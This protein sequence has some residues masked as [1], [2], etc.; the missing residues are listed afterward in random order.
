M[1]PTNRPS[2]AQL[3]SGLLLAAWLGLPTL[4]PAAP[5]SLAQVP[6][7]LVIDVQPNVFF[8][9]DDSGSMDA[10]VLK[11]DGAR[12]AHNDPQYGEVGNLSYPAAQV[13]DVLEHCVGYNV[14]AYDP[15]KEYTPW[16]GKDNAGIPFAD[17]SLANARSDP[18]N[19][20]ST[21]SLNDR[22]YFPWNDDGDGVY[23]VGEC[24]QPNLA[25]FGGNIDV[26]DCPAAGCV[27]AAN[28]DPTNFANWYSYYR[29]REYVLKRAVSPLIDASSNR[30]GM[31]SLHNTGN[32]ATPISDMTDLTP[33]SDCGA[34]TNKEC[35]LKRLHQMDAG[36]GGNTPLRQALAEAGMYYHQTDGLD[37]EFLLGDPSPILSQVEGGECQQNFTILVSDGF[38]NGN[39]P[40]PAATW[41]AATTRDSANQLLVLPGDADSDGTH[42]LPAYDPPWDGGAQA[43]DG[44][45]PAA[46]LYSDPITSN[47]LADIAMYYYETDLSP[48]PDK[49]HTNADDGNK[50]QHMVTFTVAF[51]VDGSLGS[52]PAD[53]TTPF[54]WPAI[55]A[56]EDWTVDDIRHA[57]WNG[58]GRF[59]SAQDPESVAQSLAEALAAIEQRSGTMAAVA[60][61]HSLAANNLVFQAKFDDRRWSGDLLAYDIDALV[62]DIE[63]D[64]VIDM[65]PSWSAAEKLD[66]LTDAQAGQRLVLT[67]GAAGDGVV[68]DW[69]NLPAALQTDLRTDPAGNQGSDDS[70]AARLAYLRGDRRCEAS[71]PG[72]CGTDING[73]ALI[74]AQD[75]AL[76]RR[77][78]RLGDIMNSAPV[79]VGEPELDWPSAAPFPFAPGATYR[80]FKNN[81]AA[82]TPVVY[83]GAND[84]M[85]HGFNADNGVEVLAYMPSGLARG[86]AW[87]GHHFLTERNYGHRYYVDLT[88][89]VSDVY[90]DVGLGS[91]WRTVL[92]GGPG[93]GGMGLFALDVTDPAQFAPANAVN[94]LLWEFSA[95]NEMGSVLSRPGVAMMNN[96]EWAV[97]AG[98]GFNDQ[99]GDADAYLFILFLE[100]GLDGAWTPGVD[101]IKIKAADATAVAD[102]P[103]G[104]TSQSVV[105]LDGNGT[106]DRIYAGDL[107]GNL[108]A[109]DVSNPN[110]LNWDVAADTGGAKGPLFTAEVGGTRQPITVKPALAKHPSEHDV[111]GNQPNAMVY[112]GTGKYL[113]DSDRD[114]I[115]TQ[116]A[117]GVWDRGD[118]FLTRADLEH[119][120]FDLA[121]ANYEVME[122]DDVDWFTQYGW[123]IDLPDQGERVVVD[124]V[125]RSSVLYFNSMVPSKDKCA[126]GGFSFQ[127]AVDMENG[128]TTELA[129]FDYNGDNSVD[130]ATDVATAIDGSTTEFASRSSFDGGEGIATQSSFYEDSEFTGTSADGTKIVHRKVPP[131]LTVGEGRL[132]WQQLLRQ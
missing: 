30:I 53:R 54:P 26:G 45:V 58:R 88:P 19:P 5:E 10:E 15:T 60:F 93:A 127:Y 44:S 50:Q 76:R 85:L 28:A 112:F 59:L 51:G 78:S 129:A 36:V 29:K 18:S 64:G 81:V 31:A 73:D 87:Q 48:L 32:L 121:Y 71:A 97:I 49:V 46:C 7:F 61:G 62:A 69:V 3:F 107:Y 39:W 17:Q 65:A 77:D 20:A 110:Q 120:G 37:H 13:W 94:L 90:I 95:D 116:S 33:A 8:V 43:D 111:L 75:K 35:L 91:Q 23:E 124:P 21:V 47:T 9:L 55:C 92:I 72:A 109:F 1:N 119:Q 40:T 115:D 12:A 131:L 114:S 4:A 82:R 132:S 38:W 41:R 68:A 24:S 118:L 80:D 96:G 42:T 130:D 106:A 128:G 14:L 89:S 122:D 6:L 2:I 57:A 83:V 98:S 56:Y 34:I 27:A 113:F 84:G 101:Y 104:L 70:G 25:A 108:W 86:P 11:S 63:A 99:G 123:H 22:F 67:K 66:A 16:T 102:N 79:F 100:G 103:N 105:D 52:D 126:G 125:L 74:D 117:Y